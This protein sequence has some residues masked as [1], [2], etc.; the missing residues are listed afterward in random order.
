MPVAQSAAL[1]AGGSGRSPEGMAMR[2]GSTGTHIAG[3]A[4]LGAA[5]RSVREGTMG[6][7]EM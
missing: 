7:G 6:C 5:R 4:G 1:N 2:A 3:R